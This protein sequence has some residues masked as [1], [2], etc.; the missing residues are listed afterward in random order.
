MP[1]ITHIEMNKWRQSWNCNFTPDAL[2]AFFN[3]SLN[4]LD[5]ASRSPRCGEG[6]I[7]SESGARRVRSSLRC[8]SSCELKSTALALWFFAKPSEPTVNWRFCQS[9]SFHL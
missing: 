5:E 9:T 8:A 4:V 1:L 2:R 6:N 7:Q 3:V